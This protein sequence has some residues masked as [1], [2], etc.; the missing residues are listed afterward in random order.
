MPARRTWIILALVAL[1]FGAVV[2]SWA[3]R[4]AVLSW[5]LPRVAAEMGIR[6][7]VVRV[8]SF[9]WREVVLADVR[10]G[11]G[12]VEI[13]RVAIDFTLGGL[14]RGRLGRVDVHG[15]RV[16]AELGEEGISIAPLDEWLAADPDAPLPT[17]PP[18]AAREVRLHDVHLEFST[19]GDLYEIDLEGE[20]AFV[21]EGA[22]LAIRGPLLMR[23]ES[24]PL[25][26]EAL[27]RVRLRG[28]LDYSAGGPTPDMRIDVE[29]FAASM[30]DLV[31]EEVEGSLQL[32]GSPAVTPTP[33]RFTIGRIASGAELRD[34]QVSFR[35]DE[36]SRLHLDGARFAVFGGTLRLSGAFDP[37][38]QDNPVAV[39][40][41]GIDLQRL[42][43]EA[44][45]PGLAATGSI[46]G[47][48]ALRGG[49][50]TLR[51][52]DGGVASKRGGWIRYRPPGAAPLD[53]DSPQGLDLVRTALDNFEYTSLGGTLSGD[54]RG[55]MRIALRIEGANPDLYDGHPIKLDLNLN[56][57]FLG[58]MRSSRTVTGIPDAI[59]RSIEEAD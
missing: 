8:E 40:L 32:Q 34:G 48:V 15:L 19:G 35:V 51:I 45:V 13:D 59:Q 46:D 20:L 3:Y 52:D 47:R 24:G 54:L 57:P 21:P 2:G 43:D 56:G 26:L 39:S 41:S 6:D 27:G 28:V 31:V 25:D 37:E 44:E 18:L 22:Q 36:A 58:L 55:E 42:L 16:D 17:A 23:I 29:T 50:E 9:G 1:P 14:R 10:A 11:R 38:A 53:Y 5:A 12:E 7:P 33:A 49:S 4:S 30:A